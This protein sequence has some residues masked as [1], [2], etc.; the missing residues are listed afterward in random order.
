MLIRQSCLI[1]QSLMHGHL[2]DFNGVLC[3]LLQRQSCLKSIQIFPTSLPVPFYLKDPFL[4][5]RN[6]FCHYG[7][8]PV[9][10]IC[11]QGIHD[12]SRSQG[13]RYPQLFSIGDDSQWRHCWAG[14]LVQLPLCI[15]EKAVGQQAKEEGVEI[16]RK[17]IC[18]SKLS[19]LL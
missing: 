7:H 6:S 15:G 1:L 18:L 4:K 19:V 11:C 13:Y 3:S 12:S 10:R 9:C 16:P 17:Y 2:Y 5:S 8:A 14:D